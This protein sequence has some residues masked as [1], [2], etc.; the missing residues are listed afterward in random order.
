MEEPRYITVAEL[1]NEIPDSMQGILSSDGINLSKNEPILKEKI[2]EAE[3][4]LESYVSS[5][6]PIPVKAEDG[7]VPPTVKG[8]LYVI[9]KYKLYGRRDGITQEIKEQYDT[10]MRWLRDVSR[11][12]ANIPLLDNQNQIEKVGTTSIE[13]NPANNSNFKVFV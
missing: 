9:T 6:Y 11:G 5:R 10:V 4:V 12:D 13:V 1:V 2:K 3:G 8:A 7:R